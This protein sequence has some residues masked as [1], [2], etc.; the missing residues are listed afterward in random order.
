MLEKGPID[1]LKHL[2][3]GTTGRGKALVFQDGKGVEA[4]WQKAKRVSRTL[5]SDTKG[6][7][8]A[9]N[10][11]PIWIEVAAVGREINY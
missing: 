8:I 2:L 5:F 9:F 6:K 3:Y 7:E 10:R 1:E 4:V 11:G